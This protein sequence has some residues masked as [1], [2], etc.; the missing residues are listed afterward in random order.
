MTTAE[1]TEA[2]VVVTPHELDAI[3]ALI[4]SNN[5][6][7]VV[8]G[9]NNI[10]AFWSEGPDIV[11]QIRNA[12]PDDEKPRLKAWDKLSPETQQTIVSMAAGTLDWTEDRTLHESYVQSV[13]DHDPELRA[14]LLRPVD[15]SPA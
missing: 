7:R 11:E 14:E 1:R 13:L 4:G 8:V 6:H 15:A 2:L 12:L 10:A 3:T 9:E 5:V